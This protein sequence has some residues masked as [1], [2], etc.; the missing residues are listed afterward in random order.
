M[1]KRLK[2]LLLCVYSYNVEVLTFTNRSL[3][4]VICISLRKTYPYLSELDFMGLKLNKIG[5]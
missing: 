4:R 1:Q 5:E 3:M 2:A